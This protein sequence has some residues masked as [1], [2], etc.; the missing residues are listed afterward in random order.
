VD[1]LN[2]LK[3]RVAAL[4]TQ[5]T[6]PLPFYTTALRPAASTVTGLVIR[7]TT[8]T[9]AEFSDGTTWWPLY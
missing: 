1:V 9:K 6:N 8:T 4:E 3:R 7:N 5:Q 2:D